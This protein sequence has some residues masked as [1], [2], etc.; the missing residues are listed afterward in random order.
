YRLYECDIPELRYI[1]DIY[2]A[3][4]AVYE[5]G[6][7]PLSPQVEMQLTDCVA[8][9]LELP[10]A[11]IHLKL[12]RRMRGA[13]QYEKLST[14]SLRLIVEEQGSRYIVNLSDYLDTGLFLDH[15]PLRAEFRRLAGGLRLLNLFCYTAS[16][17]VA[18]AQSGAATTSVDMSNTYLDWA[19]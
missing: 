12:R 19:K 6:K 16:I 7:E 18:A 1:I 14:D 17:S 8:G 4:A 11:H 3:H 10:P 9:A 2:L 5:L 13:N 15:R